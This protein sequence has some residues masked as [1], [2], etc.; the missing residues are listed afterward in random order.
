L[1]FLW[2]TLAP[3]DTLAAVLFLADRAVDFPAGHG[4]SADLHKLLS[5]YGLPEL[6]YCDSKADVARSLDLE[7]EKDSILCWERMSKAKSTSFLCSVFSGPRHFFEAALFVSST[8]LSALRIF[9]LMWTGSVAIHLFGSHER[10]CRFCF[11]PLDS[12]HFF[13][14]NF[15]TCQYLQLIVMARNNQFSELMRFTNQ[16]YFSFLFRSKPS[17]LSEE[18]LL[19]HDMYACV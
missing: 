10:V 1:G 18:E 15:D 7:L 17:V 3:S 16:C 12:R 4:F 14:C 8:S 13:G 9:L 11:G 5:V 2:R 19:L 6:I